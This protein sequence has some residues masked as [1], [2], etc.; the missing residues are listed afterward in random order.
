MPRAMPKRVTLAPEKKT[1]HIHLRLGS[2]R[3]AVRIHQV[4]HHVDLNRPESLLQ[5]RNLFCTYFRG[6]G[7]R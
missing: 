6:V 5:L 1:A 7:G 3:H 4:I 2:E